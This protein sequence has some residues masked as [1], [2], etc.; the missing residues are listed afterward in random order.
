MHLVLDG[1]EDIEFYMDDIGVFSSSWDDH[2]S[3]LSLVLTRLQ[4]IG[5]TINPLKCECAIQETNFLGHWLTPEGVKPWHKKIEAILRLQPPI[6][7][8][9]LRSFLGMVNYYRNMW[10]RR[11]HVLAPLT[12][13]TRKRT[14]I[15]T[16]KHQ[17]AFERMKALVAAD[18]LL[19]FP[20]HSLPFDVEMDASEYQLGSAIKQQGCPVA[21]YS[22]KL[23]SAQRNYT[24]IK[25]ELLSIVETFKEFRT[26]LLGA[27]I[28]VHMDHKNLTHCLTE[29]TTQR[30]LRWCLLFEEFNPT[31]LYK[32]GPSNVLADAL[33]C[34]QTTR[35]ERESSQDDLTSNDELM[36]C[37]SSYPILVEFPIDQEVTPL[38]NSQSVHVATQEAA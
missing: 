24:T 25:K 35:T 12:E 1:I 8:K 27:S 4:D 10:P 3:L 23:N 13:L 16:P 30:V 31:F 7:V 18:A 33:S 29:F 34:V 32:S 20:N 28:R 6:N 19:V 38:A 26:V 15:W 5:F 11:T 37:L 2:L 22:R 9:Q 21:Y 14:F 36:F 17:Q